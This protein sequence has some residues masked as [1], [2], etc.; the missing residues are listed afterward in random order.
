MQ[1]YGRP[2]ASE[3]RRG[4]NRQLAAAARQQA[5][6]DKVVEASVRGHEKVP[7]GG[8]VEVATGGQVKVPTLRVVS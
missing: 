5:V 8:Q 4:V 7:A 2:W 6:Q 3:Y 1:W